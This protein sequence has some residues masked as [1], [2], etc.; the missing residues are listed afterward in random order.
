M[1]IA[2]AGYGA[3][4]KSNYRYFKDKGEITIADERTELPDAP[5]GVP[6]ILGPDAFS[7]LGDFDLILR[8]PSVNPKKLPYDLPGRKRV[9]S[10][11]SEFFNKCPAWTIGVTGTKGKGT[12]CSLITSILRAAGKT[13]HL[14]G[15]IGVPAL[16]ELPKIK[17]D[18]IV[19]YELSSFQLWDVSGSPVDVAV[20]L[21]IEPDHLDV[22]DDMDDYVR[23]KAHILHFDCSCHDLVIYH[24]TN[25][26]TR[27]IIDSYTNEE[28]LSSDCKRYGIKDDGLVYAE[29]GYFRIQGETI[30]PVSD[31]Q[32]PGKHNIEN[33]C[34]AISAVWCMTDGIEGD[35]DAVSQGLKAFTGLPHRLK[36][37]DT[38]NGVTFYDDS[39]STTPGSAIAA[40]QSFDQPKVIILGGSGKGADYQELVEVCRETETQ[41][42]T[43]GQTGATIAR[44]CQEQ[45]VPVDD[46]GTATMDEIVNRALASARPGSVVIL[47]P[48]SASFDMFKNYSDRGDQFIGAVKRREGQR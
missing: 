8:S 48:A 47:S 45:N 34:A 32:L 44:L 26:Y 19:V 1:K 12:T 33:A 11:T 29:D 18:D 7:R 43:I 30:C 25:A 10:A 24:P 2:I 37:I 39:I 28:L 40:L 14:V 31:L 15:N 23:A 3:E 9:W 38:I 20:I 4:G 36:K 13:V 22:H 5:V 6:T 41:V 46:L 17:K 35:K 27:E 42:V 16:D 21:G